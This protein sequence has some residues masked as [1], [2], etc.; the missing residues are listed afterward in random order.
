MLQLMT[1]LPKH[2]VGVRALASVN[3]AEYERVLMPELDRVAKEFGEINF[4]M[5]LETN[6]GNFSPGAWMD[7]VKA[8]IKHFKHWHRVAIVTDQKAVQKFTDFFSAIIPGESKGFPISDIELAKG[9]VAAAKTATG[10]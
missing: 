10:K 9:W 1:D 4:I 7:D 6:V 3:K 5:V 2:V 8:G